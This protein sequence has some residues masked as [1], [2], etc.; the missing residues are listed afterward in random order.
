MTSSIAALTW[1]NPSPRERLLANGWVRFP[2]HP[3]I[4]AWARSVRAL[5]LSLADDP[6]LRRRL[7]RCGGTWF[8][9]VNA[10][11]NATDGSVDE[12][13]AP[14]I[15]GAVVDF[16][17]NDLGFGGFDWDRAQISICYPGYPAW[18]P[19]EESAAAYRF[20]VERHAAHVDGFTRRGQ[21]RF[22]GETHGFV[23]GIPLSNGRD[24]ASPLSVWEG[25]HELFRTGL[26]AA[27]EGHRV[28]EWGTI[29][30][31][32]TYV[33]LRRACFGR[34][35]RVAVVASLGEA[36]LVHRLALH[37]IAPWQAH[38]GETARAVIYLRPDPFP[39]V[40]P[41]WWL[42]MP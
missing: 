35:R 42:N 30:L 39:G 36:Y 14:P 6:D 26:Q 24:R 10:L 31:T 27:L 25:S 16:L 33:E 1:M 5:A 40:L 41:E 4:E 19:V 20:R 8:A 17:R 22:L 38:A 23:L 7:L 13:G 32:D 21:R 28:E 3:L 34:L 11:R 18:D 12:C 15:A 9:G 29:D 2:K 37:G